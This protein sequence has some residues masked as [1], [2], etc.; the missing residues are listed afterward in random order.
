MHNNNGNKIYRGILEIYVWKM[1]WMVLLRQSGS[2]CHDLK[3]GVGRILILDLVDEFRR[4][5]ER[6]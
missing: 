2:R 6:C 3:G 1:Q 4:F 5:M